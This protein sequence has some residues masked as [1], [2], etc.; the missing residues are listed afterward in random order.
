MFTVPPV[1]LRSSLDVTP[2]AE[3]SIL[4]VPVPLRTTSSFEK[5]TAS[6]LVSPSAVNSP[7][8]ARVFSVSVVVT[9]TL[10]ALCT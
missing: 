2:L 10:S 9:N 1:I 5:M 4:S 6:V 7:V 8:T 3:D